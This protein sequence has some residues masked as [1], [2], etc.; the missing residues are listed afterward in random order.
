LKYIIILIII[1]SNGFLVS[2]SQEKNE[3]SGKISGENR[4]GGQIVIG[5]NNDAETLNPIFCE[6]ALSQE[7]VHLMMLGL[8]DLD[9]NSQF[10]PE[11]AESWESSEDYLKL[12]YKLRKNMVWSDG[13]PISAYDVKFTYDLLM[14]TLVASPRQS[15]CD[16]IKQV[17]VVDSYTV[18]FE[19]TE[20]YPTQIFDTAGE[21]LPRHILEKVNRKQIR[22]HGFG[23]MPVASGPFKL[24]KWIPQQYIELEPN[25]RYF[26][27]R[28]YLDNVI[29]KII[30]DKTN[31]LMQLKSGE[32]DMAA[33]VPP[34]EIADIKEKENNIKLYQV[35]GRV[36]YFIG[37]NNKHKLFSDKTIRRALTMALDRNKIIDALLFGYGKPCLGPLPP[38]VKWAYN[39]KVKAIPYNPS[40]AKQLLEQAGWQDSDNDGILDKDGKKFEFTLSSSAG[41]QL[42]SD[43]AVITQEQLGKIGI[44][45]NI[46]LI[47][48]TTF[49]DKI[50]SKNFDACVNGWST[51]YYV[52]PTP[53][54]HS[55]ATDMFNFVSYSNPV[56]DRLIEKGRMQMDQAAAADTWKKFHKIIYDDQPYTFLFWIDQVVAVKSRYKNVRPLALSSVYDLENWYIGSDK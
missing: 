10:K 4:Y 19:F 24:K 42:K 26:G 14:D 16:F 9:E 22:N 56:V 6:S 54:F 50:Q 13:Y 34:A 43:V 52:D 33:D 48:W 15:A 23:R 5:V 47:E 20:A 53:V 37:Y 28:A 7:V 44:K 11:L 21:I 29:F 38:M 27:R 30:P 25:D 2:C 8:A 18:T 46:E 49:I 31:L 3:S 36:Y 41:N 40:K 45:V 17:S 32:I 35:D 12:T 1:I 51:P 39:D 55:D